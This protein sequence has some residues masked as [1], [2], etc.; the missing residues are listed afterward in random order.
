[1]STASSNPMAIQ[2]LLQLLQFS[3]PSLPVGGFAWSQGLEAAIE[4]GWVT[5]EESLVDWLQAVASHGFVYQEWPLL[6]RCHRAA[7]TSDLDELSRWN[8]T[9]L[10]LRETAEFY[11]QDTL[12]ASALLKLLRDLNVPLAQQ[13]PTQPTSYLTAFALATT[14]KQIGEQDACVALFWSWL[15]N[16]LAVSIKAIPMGQT[17]AQQIFQQLAPQVTAWLAS[18]EQVADDAIGWTLPGVVMASLQHETQ[19][20]RLFRS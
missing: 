8:Q 20:S 2:S 16:Q 4:L 11:Q 10:A 6:Q 18:S 17:L 14:D 1:M 7:M 5:A 9:V 19:Y 13:W 12:M 3:S 15:E